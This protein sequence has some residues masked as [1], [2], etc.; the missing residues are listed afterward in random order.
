MKHG[1]PAVG[2]TTQQFLSTTRSCF[3]IEFIGRFLFWVMLITFNIVIYICIYIYKLA[4]FIRFLLSS[5]V[6]FFWDMKKYFV[7]FTSRLLHGTIHQ[8][9]WYFWVFI[10][11]P[12]SFLCSIFFLKK[13][14]FPLVFLSLVYCWVSQPRYF[15]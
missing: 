7:K 3:S 11:N 1:N 13:I 2:N 6:M 8:M 5:T 12:F 15:W 4:I 10:V 14:V 9:M